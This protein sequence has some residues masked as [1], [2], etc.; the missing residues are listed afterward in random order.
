MGSLN[1][2]KEA[3]KEIQ[4]NILEIIQNGDLSKTILQ[5]IKDGQSSATVNVDLS[6]LLT[7]ITASNTK[8]DSC[9]TK[10]DS[11]NTKLDS[12][13]SAINSKNPILPVSTATKFTIAS[14]SIPLGTS[15]NLFPANANRKGF[16]I[17]NNS[18]N[19]LYV[20][21]EN[22]ATAANLI[23]FC[24]SNAGPTAV[25]KWFGPAVPTQAIYVIRNAGTGGVTGWEFT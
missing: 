24:A 15:V 3:L 22:P 8:L 16:T 18:T 21:I 4:D 17:Y 19:S 23:D 10:L 11:S 12:L 6:P 7:A 25:V 2:F 1:V 13:I 9:N 5:N 14:A 20:C